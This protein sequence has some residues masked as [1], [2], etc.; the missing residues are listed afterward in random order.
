MFLRHTYPPRPRANRQSSYFQPIFAL[1]DHQLAMHLGYNRFLIGVGQFKTKPL[2]NRQ[3]ARQIALERIGCGGIVIIKSRPIGNRMRARIGQQSSPPAANGR[4][5]KPGWSSTAGASG[6]LIGVSG[7]VFGN[8]SDKE[9][10]KVSKGCA[11]APKASKRAVIG[12]AFIA[13]TGNW[14]CSFSNRKAGIKA[15]RSISGVDDGAVAEA[16]ANPSA[17]NGAST[18]KASSGSEQR[19]KRASDHPKGEPYRATIRALAHLPMPI[20]PMPFER[21]CPSDS[22]FGCRRPAASEP[23]TPRRTR[24]MRQSCPG[25]LASKA[26]APLS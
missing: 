8:V 11:C 19:L 7:N 1:A 3:F 5:S 23:K 25:S 10:I 26:S 22:A 9:A 15:A 20:P 2:I 21:H 4:S 18:G 12:L 17:L 14:A 6:A 24:A 13:S 16:A